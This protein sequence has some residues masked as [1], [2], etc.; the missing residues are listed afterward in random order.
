MSTHSSCPN[1]HGSDSGTAIYQCLEC[2][3]IFCSECQAVFGKA[4]LG[5]VSS[6][7]SCR[8]QGHTMGEIE[9]SRDQDDASSS[10]VSNNRGSPDGYGLGT[11]LFG[12]PLGWA[13]GGFVLWIAIAFAINFL[14]YMT[15]DGPFGVATTYRFWEACFRWSSYIAIPVSVGGAVYS[16]YRILSDRDTWARIGTQ[17]VAIIVIIFVIFFLSVIGKFLGGQMR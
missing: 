7:P 6:C 2:G 5:L 17:S 1:C 11:V 3:K 8:G 15:N 16:W 9:N 13:V 14:V 10:V 4:S 12:I